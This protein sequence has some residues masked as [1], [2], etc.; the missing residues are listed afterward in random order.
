VEAGGRALRERYR[1]LYLKVFQDM[2]GGLSAGMGFGTDVAL[3]LAAI[4]SRAAGLPGPG[5]VR[6]LEAAAL[7]RP[8]QTATPG[9]IRALAAE[10]IAGLHAVAGQLEAC[11]S[12]HGGIWPVPGSRRSAPGSL[13]APGQPGEP[14][15][16]YLPRLPKWRQAGREGCRSIANGLPSA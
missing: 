9:Q 4:R 5:Q 1:L 15:R 13:Q 7:A 12:A 2:A 14:A 6:A 3:R 8:G 10:S 11:D 16:W